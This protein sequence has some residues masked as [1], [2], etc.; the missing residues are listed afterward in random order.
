MCPIAFKEW[1][2]V[3]DALIQGRQALIIRKGGISETAGPGNFDPEFPEFWLYP[4]R[5]HQAEQGLRTGGR[6]A[7]TTPTADRPGSVSIGGFVTVDL[8]AQVTREKTLP[9]LEEFHVFTAETILKRFHY[10]RPGFWVL[11]ARVWRRDPGFTV[12]MTPEQA[13]CKTWLTL[14]P[15]LSTSGLFSVLDD[16]EWARLRDRLRSVLDCEN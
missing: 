2:G 15:P 10:R 16:D 5:V 6:P 11:G 4:T 8:V 13:G 3:C 14:D 7:G 9:L 12:A 1:A